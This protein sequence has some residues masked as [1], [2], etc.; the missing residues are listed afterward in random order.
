METNATTLSISITVETLQKLL[1]R[2]KR[3]I[4]TQKE[5]WVKDF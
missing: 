3:S 1:T 5:E 2:E 4:C